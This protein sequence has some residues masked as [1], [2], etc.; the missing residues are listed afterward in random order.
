MS[1]DFSSSSADPNSNTPEALTLQAEI[2]YA[3]KQYADAIAYC[4]Q[5]ILQQP[6][7][8][9]AYVT[10]GNVQQAQGS[11]DAAIR[12]YQQALELDSNLAPAHANLGSM[13]YKRGL[14]EAAITCYRQ[15]LSLKPDFAAVYWNLAQALR[16]QGNEPEA[17]ICEQKVIEYNPEIVGANF[18]FNQ[19][20]RLAEK[21]QLDAAV[22]SWKIAIALDPNLAEAY[23]Q[24]GMILRYRGEK[25]PAIS[26][27]KKALELEPSLIPAHQHL[28]GIFRDSSDLASARQAVNQYRQTCGEND[29]IMTAI[30]SISTHQVSGLNQIAKDQFLLLESQLD[31]IL[32]RTTDIEIRSLYSNFLF[33]Q[34]YLR[35]RIVENSRLI[36]KI[37]QR[38]IEQ[39]LQPNRSLYCLDYPQSSPQQGLKIG[40][41]SNHFN[42]HAVGWC[43]L[44]IIRALSQIT[45]EI[46]LYCT[47]RLKADD[48]TELFQE[49]AHKFYQPQQYPNGLA[50]ARE[51]TQ[52]I[53]QDEIEILIDLD[54]ISMPIHTEILY[55]QPAPVC[56]SWLGFDAT[57]ISDKN[58]FLCDGNTHPEGRE[59]YYTEKLVRMPNSFVAV[60]GFESVEVNRDSIRKA[61]RLGS[62]QI[63]YLNVAPGRKFNRELVEA[64]IAILKQVPNSVLIHKAMGDIEVFQNAYQQVCQ[65]EGVSFHRVKFVPRFP[66][67]E[68][69]RQIYALAD[70]LLDS[71]PYN[72]GTH[73][74][75]ALWFEVP[76]VTFKGEQFL[77][78]MGYSFLR[79]VGVEAGVAES[80]EEYINW[81]VRLGKDQVLRTS[82]Q[83]QLKEA[84]TSA[85]LA[86]LWN[87]TLFAENLYNI[88]TQLLGD[89]R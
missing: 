45:P 46:Y 77:S 29:P 40:I 23:C 49:I 62:D 64:Q 85:N 68:E 14:L 28:C 4:Q 53:R 10:L 19:G 47:D 5:A 56:I 44:D 6:S 41:L 25:K 66:S 17:Q 42:R 54:T 87:P 86:P 13:Y 71:Y 37:A 82:V 75:E 88:C 27:F 72:G 83:T 7:W 16:K 59:E 60:S 78:R 35:D 69:H 26:Y 57:Y 30:Y 74:L 18:I 2:S 9:A 76:V 36:Q 15:A 8:A 73:T 3:Q 50:D 33:S 61:Y 52:E 20:N 51:I 24:I 11:L 65:A 21:G 63:V 89:H 80:W 70:I 67:E 22:N 81:G 34:P 1:P 39:I 48:L 58:Y 38:Y 12:S 79:G 55:A 32:N 43:S 31:D 84:K